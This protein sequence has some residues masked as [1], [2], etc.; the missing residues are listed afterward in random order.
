ML[1]QVETAAQCFVLLRPSLLG[2]AKK[3]ACFF[4]VFFAAAINPKAVTGRE[5]LSVNL[6][7]LEIDQIS[8]LALSDVWRSFS[9][10]QKV[11]KYGLFQVQWI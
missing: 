8:P 10:G 1:T 4:F 6:R 5:G 9:D 2:E 7:A 11:G 3:H